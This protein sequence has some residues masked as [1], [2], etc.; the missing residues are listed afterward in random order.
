MS[1][2]YSRRDFFKKTSTAGVAGAVSLLPVKAFASN[3]KAVEYTQKTILALSQSKMK[4]Q[5][6]VV[7]VGS[8]YGGSVAAARLSKGNS[9][10]VLERGQE[11][12]PGDFPEG[13]I[14]TVSQLK[15]SQN[16]LGLYDLS[17]YGDATVVSASGLGGT[18][19]INHGIATIPDNDVFD[20][21]RWPEAIRAD[22]DNGKLFY[23]YAQARSMLMPDSFPSSIPLVKKAEV[24]RKTSEIL[25][26]SF[27]I[28]NV[29][30]NYSRYDKENNHAGVWQN[31]CIQCGNC[32]TGCNVGAKNTI[33]MNYLPA[34]KN[35]GAEMFTGI[36]VDYFTKLSNGLYR[37]YFK[38]WGA[39]SSEIFSYR[40]YLGKGHVDT[41]VL[42]ISAGTM[43]SNKILQRSRRYGD[44]DFSDKL[45]SGFSGNGDTLGMGFNGDDITNIESFGNIQQEPY[46]PIVGPGSTSYTKHNGDSFNPT[47]RFLI[48][49]S[50]IPK[51]VVELL[52][53]GLFAIGG[54]PGSL[55]DI[56]KILSDVILR[57]DKGALNHSQLYLGVGHDNSNGVIKM[58]LFGNFS[59]SWK[60]IYNDSVWKAVGNGMKEHSE[61]QGAHYIA[62]P[63][64]MFTTHPLGGCGMAES[65]SEGIVD[66]RCRV[67]DPRNKKDGV[68]KNLYVMD[69]SIVPH[70]LGT[71]PS[72]TIT[73]L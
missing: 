50:S 11:Y 14:N 7:V 55:K 20:I 35:N 72:F 39:I 19:L 31:K 47:D 57:S 60:S 54:L 33:N 26:A 2:K 24:L 66:D 15:S 9:L 46:E 49:D 10:C 73:A 48:E 52:K 8:G 28:A 29:Y 58:D 18:S 38:R 56:A 41:A 4:K 16:H 68:H 44:M 30:V 71:N 27:S 36:E 40:K 5:Y 13:L 62:N 45:G 34:A 17:P 12:H 23:Y 51:A 6:D 21:D 53:T 37:V 61:I 63:L 59:I 32:L 70:S 43:G 1:S 65:V 22:R 69:G 64:G 67:F 3:K 42:V 25:G